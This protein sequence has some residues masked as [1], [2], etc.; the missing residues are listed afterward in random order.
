MMMLW[1]RIVVS[2]KVIFHE[3]YM[4]EAPYWIF[5]IP[6]NHI[7]QIYQAFYPFLREGLDKFDFFNKK[8]SRFQ[9]A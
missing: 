4:L 9:W 5:R 2:M 1:M 7:E 6:W 8:P 3:G